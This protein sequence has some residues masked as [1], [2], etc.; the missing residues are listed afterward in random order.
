MLARTLIRV[1]TR[2]IEP[3]T[4][5]GWA[6]CAPSPGARITPPELAQWKCRRFQ[7]RTDHGAHRP[8]GHA[9]GARSAPRSRPG[10]V[11]HR[12]PGGGHRLLQRPAFGIRA[13]G[14]HEDPP[15]VGRGRLHERG[16][17]RPGR[18]TGAPSRRRPP[19][20]SRRPSQASAYAAAVVSISPRLASART[21]RPAS[22]ASAISRSS[23][24]MPAASV[25]LEERDLGLDHRH[26][27]R[28]TP[29]RRRGRRSAGPTRRRSAPTRRGARPRGRCPRTAA[30]AARPPP[31]PA[32]RSCQP[33]LPFLRRCR[34]LAVS[35]QFSSPSPRG[36]RHADASTVV[37]VGSHQRAE[38]AEHLP[39]R[40]GV[41]EGRRSHLDGVGPGQQQLDGV[42]GRRPRP[43]TPTMAD[44]G[45]GRPALPH[46]AHRHR[47]DGA[48]RQ[49][50]TAGAEHRPARLEVERQSRAGC[51]TRVSPSAPAPSAAPAIS[52]TSGTFGLSLAHRGRPHAVA[53]TTRAV[54]SAEWAN[55]RDRS[56]T[57][58]QLTLTSSAAMPTR[59]RAGGA[60]ATQLGRAWRSPPP[61]GPRCSPRHAPDVAAAP[62]DRRRATRPVRDPAGRRC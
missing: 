37:P 36:P 62:G 52:T 61:S 45:E 2:R 10:A 7:R 17:A 12:A 27:A 6:P 15:A 46:R 8:G 25:A 13:P 28:R 59:R 18:D 33:S 54:A 41:T 51:S 43:P 40:P 20:C 16:A 11:L 55:I 23:S 49:P 57:L 31:P 34:H 1:R 56:S 22:A 24:A 50:A 29:R 5:R 30:R 58:G 60:A 26:R 14:H 19:G 21:R 32:L 35:A 9:G 44:V 47:V 42:V 39:G 3:A 4:S 48:A 38:L 53:A